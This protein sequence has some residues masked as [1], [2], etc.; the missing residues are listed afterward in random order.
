MKKLILLTFS[1]TLI[2]IC[3]CDDTATTGG[4]L[5]DPFNIGGGGGGTG[6]V[7][8]TISSR[9]G[10][11][12][13]T[14]FSGTPSA[15]VTLSVLTVSVPAQQY[16]ESFNFDGTTVVSANV[17]EDLVQYPANS[18]VARGQQWTFQFQGTL[19]SNGQAYNITSNY[20]IP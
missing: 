12:G 2:F 17:T 15:A 6:T 5:T 9:T 4:T 10:Q 14:I 11:Q 8:I 13:E 18:G 16:S 19:A 20:T 1:I 7:T 3:S